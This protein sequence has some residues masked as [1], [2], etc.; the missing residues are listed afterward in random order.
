MNSVSMFQIGYGNITGDV[1]VLVREIGET[2]RSSRLGI[3]P[4]RIAL[5]VAVKTT[6]PDPTSTRCTDVDTSASSMRMSA[7][8]ITMADDSVP[9]IVKVTSFTPAAAKYG[10]AI[11]IVLEGARVRL[12]CFACAHLGDERL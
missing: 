11:L 2:M 9:F 10:E 4:I 7:K 1:M 3:D 12:V 8:V 6:T 5:L